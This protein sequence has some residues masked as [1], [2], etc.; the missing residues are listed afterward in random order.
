LPLFKKE[1]ETLINISNGHHPAT[2]LIEPESKMLH[3]AWSKS[4]YEKPSPELLN[5]VPQS[6]RSILSVGCGWGMTEA[7]LKKRGAQVTA[8]ALDSVIGSLAASAG[9]EMVNATLRE[10]LSQL[11]GRRFDCVLI[12]DLLRLLPDPWQTLQACVRLLEPGGHI[13]IAE[14]N[15]HALPIVVKRRLGVRDYPKLA[16]FTESGIYVIG[17][18]ALKRRLK[19]LGLGTTN[20]HWLHRT[21][22]GMVPRLL[23]RLGPLGA[24]RWILSAQKQD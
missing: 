6:A 21:S 5:T 8:L 19:H 13:I 2:T 23:R 20:V 16:S 10:S 17:V 7:E 9:I 14:V 24:E 3:L 1:I 22:S 4:L 18:R 11:S 15:F 12:S